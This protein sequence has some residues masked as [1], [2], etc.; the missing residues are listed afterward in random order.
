MGAWDR[1]YQEDGRQA[2]RAASFW[3]TS[4]KI[5]DPRGSAAIPFK[6]SGA[7]CGQV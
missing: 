1:Y 6:T 2:A 5:F 4:E 7:G 3:N